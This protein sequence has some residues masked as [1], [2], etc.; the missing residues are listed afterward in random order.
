[1]NWNTVQYAAAGSA[2]LQQEYSRPRLNREQNAQS[3]SPYK[4]TIVIK[5]ISIAVLSGTY[6]SRYMIH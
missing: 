2:Y 3:E 4:V 1:M 6:S 5:N